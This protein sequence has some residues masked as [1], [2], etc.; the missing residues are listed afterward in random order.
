[1][2]ESVNGG[3]DAYQPLL[4]SSTS[5][6]H[7]H[8]GI[9][10][11]SG[12][13]VSIGSNIGGW[14]S[15]LLIIGAEFAETIAF[16]GIS[17]NLINYLTGPLGQSTVTAAANINAWCCVGLGFLTLS[18]VLPSRKSP[19]EYLSNEVHGASS[20]PFLVILFFF[21]LYLVAVGKA[22][23]KPCAEA[24]G[25]D[26]FDERNPEECTSKSSFFN[27]WYFGLCVGSCISRFTLHTF[28]II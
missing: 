17:S 5:I 12:E 20:A 18:V 3:S 21:S 26:Q 7:V 14:R 28:K 25:A 13:K 22:G 24:F 10:D 1:M 23:F 6:G 11:Y 9:V 16:Y 4:M 19:D 15:A 8:E 2:A 27:W